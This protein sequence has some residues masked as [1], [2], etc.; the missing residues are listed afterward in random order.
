MEVMEL[1]LNPTVY[2]R[3]D[4]SPESVV[5]LKTNY[6]FPKLFQHRS[7]TRQQ[8]AHTDITQQFNESQLP[9]RL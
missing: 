1:Q 2:I 4:L 9:G 5:E 7:R 8:P 6:N 3:P